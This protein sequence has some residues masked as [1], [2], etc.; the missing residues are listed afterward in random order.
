MSDALAPSLHQPSD[1][2]RHVACLGVL[3]LGLD[4]LHRVALAQI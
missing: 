2:G 4:H 3:V 1:F